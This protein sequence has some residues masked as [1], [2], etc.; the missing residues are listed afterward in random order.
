MSLRPT[1]ILASPW[2]LHSDPACITFQSRPAQPVTIC[3]CQVSS[4]AQFLFCGFPFRSDGVL[5]CCPHLKTAKSLYYFLNSNLHEISAENFTT[6][7]VHF[8][9]KFLVKFS[10]PFLDKTFNILNV[11]YGHG[12]GW[13]RKI[14]AWHLYTLMVYL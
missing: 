1:V 4:I 11:R 9:R 5:E 8:Q 2:L 14:N 13:S 3:P 10:R 6:H 12:G 7:S